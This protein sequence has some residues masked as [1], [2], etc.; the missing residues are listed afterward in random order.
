MPLRCLSLLWFAEAHGE[1]EEISPQDL[2]FWF[3]YS[4]RTKESLRLGVLSV[5]AIFHQQ[6]GLCAKL[7]GCFPSTK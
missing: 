1:V 6:P 7:T 2:K 4:Y 3:G 5:M